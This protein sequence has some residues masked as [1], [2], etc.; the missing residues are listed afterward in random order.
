MNSNEYAVAFVVRGRKIL[1][2]N[3]IMNANFQEVLSDMFSYV[4]SF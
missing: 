1:I 4:L 3:A 2:G